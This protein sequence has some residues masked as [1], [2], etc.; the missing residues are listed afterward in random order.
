MNIW[1]KIAQLKDNKSLLNGSMFAIFS[2]INQGFNFLLLLILANFI[3]PAEYGYLSLF[4]T[5]VLVLSYFRAMSTEG[6]MSVAYFRDGESG[7]KKSVSNIV[8]TAL[9]TTLLF[10]LLLLFAG[11]WLAGV[12]SLPVGVIAL[13][14]V[15]NF[16]SLFV[17][18]NLDYFRV[19]E[20]VKLYGLFSCTNAL[21]NFVL[22][23]VLIKDF[24]TGWEGRVY[25]QTACYALF[26]I[27][28]VVLL[29]GKGYIGLPDK[30]YWKEMLCWGIP[31]IPH[32]ASNFIRQG[33]DRYIINYF[34]GIDEVGL[35]SFALNLTSVIL[36]LG[37]GFNQSN[38]VEIY[39]VLGDSSM[40]NKEKRRRIDAQRRL[41]ARIF[42]LFTIAVGLAG[43]FIVP[44]IF[45]QYDGSKYYF[46][47]LAVFGFFSCIYFLWTN[48]LFY[49]KKTKTIMYITVS[50][51]VLH[52]LLSL[53]LTRY[54]L[55]IT[56]VVYSVSQVLIV[57]LIRWQSLKVLKNQL[58]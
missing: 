54:S 55:Y 9:I 50:M 12:L 38:S 5:V 11:E 40:T 56:A 46:A 4:N 7:V 58:G 44:L 32:L 47:L 17:A 51:S 18:L 53:C 2:F 48:Y 20:N 24:S 42:F 29:A 39:K 26:G 45:P 37:I 28:G 34:H 41:F 49:Y 31:L 23:V 21:L 19:R 35:F 33:C 30:K 25:S 10:V 8:A 52:L 22:T 43:F 57:L 36:M 14:V 16:V 6:F 13:A 3:A 15:I 27:I 1:G